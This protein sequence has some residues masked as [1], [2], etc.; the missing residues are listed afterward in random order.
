[1]HVDGVIWR[2]DISAPAV[3]EA[4]LRRAQ[5]Y[6]KM[7]E[8]GRHIGFVRRS[9]GDFWVARVRTKEGSYLQHR[10]GP[11]DGS[12]AM[13]FE[14]AV[15]AARTWFATPAVAR[16]AASS[17]PV[18]VRRALVVSPIGEEF[19][20]AHAMS[21][22]VEWK[23]IVAAKSHFETNLSLINFHIIPRLGNMAVAEFNGEVLKRFC[24]EV[25]ETPPK[26]GNRPVGPRQ[27]IA[28]LD[29]Q[30]LQRRRKTVNTLIGIFR[31][32][33]Q[34]AWENGRVE[35]D[36]AWRC[37][38]RLPAV[39]RPRTLHLSREESRRLLAV[40]RPDLRRLVLGALYTGCRMTELVRMRC[41]Q[42]GRDGYGLYIAP[43]KN[44]RPR[45][46]FLP[47]EA[48]LWFLQMVRGKGRDDLVFTRDCGKPWFGNQKG[49]F[50]QAVREAQLPE[51]FTFHGLRHTYASQLIGAGSTIFAVADQ[52]GHA[53]PTTVLRTYGHLSPQIRESEVRQRF[54]TL[55]PINAQAAEDAFT[56]LEEWRS[57]L[58]GTAWREYARIV[59]VAPRDI[60]DRRRTE[61]LTSS[62]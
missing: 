61:L 15:D 17:F 32:A 51:D 30:A 39:D 31:V 38:R 40:C 52:L 16:Y 42:V 18:G 35:S 41:S 46:V 56:E 3:R 5:P 14:R 48:M 50:K 22:Y 9:S 43:S 13:A 37:L 10:L 59:D 20:V 36:R 34:T 7:L 19:S 11:A 58:H 29:D 6:W 44:Y 27:S 54:T 47:D 2:P 21:D 57:G 12:Q 45:F 53:D 60:W 33:F 25:L 28:S 8:Y 26:R 1:M 24:R 55:D 23:R 49:L 4:L 62:E